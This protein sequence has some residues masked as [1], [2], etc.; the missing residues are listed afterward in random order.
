QIIP[1]FKRLS[2]YIENE[3]VTRPN[4]AITSLPN[5]EALY[6]Q[7]LKFHTSTSLNAAEIHEMGLA[8]VKCIQS[9][10]AK[11]VKQLGYNMTVP[12]FSENIKNDPKFF[13]E[14]SEDLL[15]G[16][17]DICFNK[18]PPKLPSIF[19]SVPTLDMR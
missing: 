17:E 5:G 2:D 8:E 16:F 13:Y 3:Y 1:A 9:E 14:K 15:A 19:R 12:E 18:I 6:N 7:L 10:M 11:I 4:I